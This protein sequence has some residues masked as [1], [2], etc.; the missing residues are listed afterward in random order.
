MKPQTDAAWAGIAD[1][2]SA[3]WTTD[4]LRCMMNRLASESSSF[5]SNYTPLGGSEHVV[6][7][8]DRASAAWGKRRSR[9]WPLAGASPNCQTDLPAAALLLLFPTPALTS[10]PGLRF[11]I[12]PPGS[13]TISAPV[14]CC[15]SLFLSVVSCHAVFDA[16]LGRCGLSLRDCRL[17]VLPR[18]SL[19]SA[20]PTPN[21]A[22][23]IV[24]ATGFAPFI[25]LTVVWIWV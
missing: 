25:S 3:S 12:H 14:G 23:Y 11:T 7:E 8:A 2:S 21:H 18:N 22:P 10:A 20:S 16:C 15:L 19:A 9:D 13:T 1:A 17:C 4:C 5:N 24:L 6:V